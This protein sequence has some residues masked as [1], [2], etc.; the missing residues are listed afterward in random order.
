MSRP[1]PA[2]AD[3]LLEIGSEEIPAGY[4][5]AAVARL[6]ENLLGVLDENAVEYRRDGTQEFA[7]PRRLAVLVRDVA[8]AQRERR[9]LKLGPAVAAAFDAQGRP[10]PAAQGFARSAGVPVEGLGRFASPRGERVG[11]QVQIGGARTRDLLLADGLAEHLI[12]L[13]FPKTMRW[14]PGSALAYA[15][16]IRWLV[17]LLGDEEIPLRLEHLVA[18][19]TTRGH[20]T[21]DDRPVSLRHA[22]D[23]ETELACAHVVARA[24]L[25]G[26]RVQQEARRIAQQ[27]GGRL[28]EDPDLLEEVTYLLEHPWP[29]TGS[30]DPA[31]VGVLPKEVIITAMRAHQRYFSVERPDGTLVPRFITFRDGGDRAL[32]NVVQG[33]ERVL[34]ARLNDALFYW[35]EDRAVPSDQKLERLARIVWLE[36]Y[37][38]VRDK[39]ERIAAL[40]D[41]LAGALR[42]PVDAA[43]LRRAALLCKSDLGSEMIKDGKEFTKLQGVIG[44]YYALEAHEPAEVADVVLEHLYPRFAGDRLPAGTLA[45]L[46]ALADRLDSIAGCALAGF[47]PS[48]GQDPYALR[49]QSLAV[50]RILVEQGWHLPLDDWTRRALAGFTATDEQRREALLQT[51][52]LYWGRLETYLGDLPPEIVRA[53]LSVSPLDPVENVRAARALA[54]F[55]GQAGFGMLL[56]GAKRCR[57]IL[58]KEGELPEEALA[59]HIRAEQLQQRARQRWEAWVAHAAGGAAPGFSSQGLREPA[60]AELY[61][62]A[63]SAVPR[64][65]EGQQA[66]DYEAVYATL[67]GLG[68]PIDRYF[69]AV[70]VNAPDPELRR[71]RLAFL[72][73][74]H[75]MFARFADL[76]R[77]PPPTPVGAERA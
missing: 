49:R 11:A 19:R 65:R 4:I 9:E 17:C 46:V 72:E 25:R 36:G 68:A 27:A 67:A 30:Y 18:G 52:D 32:A 28:H 60:E 1:E 41:G 22:A 64:L 24:A 51:D 2:S 31:V 56:L 54:A 58:V 43:L 69:T 57:N 3:L 12:A 23:Y 50:L 34:R 16:P 33:N 20:R 39:C 48:A 61:A 15:R 59:P 38:S 71:A 63:L 14:I 37:G 21:L 53:V 35:N 77:V 44:R 70:L 40:A 76:S 13:G 55:Q 74:L 62:A 6:R 8:L 47:A 29:V 45:L 42:A 5:P 26:E 75:Y 10:T 66:G 7:T 73:A